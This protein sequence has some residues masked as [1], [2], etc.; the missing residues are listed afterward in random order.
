MVEDRVLL[1]TYKKSRSLPAYQKGEYAKR[2]RLLII[3]A[4]HTERRVSM[5]KNLKQALKHW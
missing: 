3:E 2:L 5:T 4:F 1:S